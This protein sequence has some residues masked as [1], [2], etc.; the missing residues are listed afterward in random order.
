MQD[1][2]NRALQQVCNDLTRVA[3]MVRSD[4]DAVTSSGNY[5]DVIRHFNDVRL[6]AAQIKEAR[7]ALKSMEDML[8]GNIVPD[9]VRRAK[10]ELGVKTPIVLEG[11]GRVTVSY[12]FSASMLDKEK[13]IDWLKGNGHGGLVQETVNSSTLSAF[14]KDMFENQGVELPPEVFKVGTN[15]YTSI[16][17]VK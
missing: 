8:S 7:E 3:V 16:T 2:T 14:A 4:Q 1:S 11:V 10:E 17:K 13:G 15:P 9:F 6:A 5:I 12:R